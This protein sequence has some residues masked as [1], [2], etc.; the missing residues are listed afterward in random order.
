MLKLKFIIIILISFLSINLLAQQTSPEMK[1]GNILLKDKKYIE[2]IMIFKE[3][4]KNNPKNSMAWYYIGTA[5]YSLK[6]YEEAIKAYKMSMEGLKGSVVCYNL[7]GVYALSGDKENA[8]KWLEIAASKGFGQ[9]KTLEK[10]TDFVS[11]NHEER[12]K[13]LLKKIEI[14]GN[15]CLAREEYS[16]FNFW[17]GK[18]D[19]INPAGKH[20]GDSEIELMNNGCT[21]VENWYGATGFVGKSFNYFDSTDNK[22]HQFWINQNAQKTTFEGKLEN[23]NM[24][25][26]SYDHVKD[27]KNPYLERLTFFNLGNNKVR[28]YDEK[29]TDN[30]K[31]WTVQYDLTYI[32]KSSSN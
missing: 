32:R 31:T 9:N 23:G 12:F 16:Q 28:Q 13:K 7:A 10:D 19:V 20:A 25:F 1:K 14:I 26:Y 15:P 4:L 17:I 2:A 3:E 21:L 30:G 18:W 29:T 27:K 22:W 5:E 6:N 11:I 8:Y 24:V